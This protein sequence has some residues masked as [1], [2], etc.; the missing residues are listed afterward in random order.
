MTLKYL[1]EKEFKQFRRNS[2]L[3]KLVIMFPIMIM[4][5]IPWVATL[6]IKD[7]NITIVDR[8]NT[9]TSGKLIQKI[10]ASTYF[11][12]KEVVND[13]NLAMN[14][15][16]RGDADI[17]LEIPYG[18]ERHFVRSEQPQIYIAANAVNGTK[19]ALGSGY[20]NAIVSDF[21]AEVIAAQGD[22]VNAPNNEMSVLNLY[23]PTLNYRLF[24]I[25]AL[26]VM[27]VILLCGFLPTLNIVSEKE[28]GTIEQIN[29]TPV[30]KFQFI[31]AKLI[32]YWIIGLVVLTI[33]FALGWLVYG[34]LPAGSFIEIYVAAL[35]F[36]LA[37]SGLGLLVSNYSQTM[38][39]AMLVMF[40]FILIFNLMSGL[41]T[42]V[43]SMP[44]WAQWVAA[45]T[46]PKYFIEI[47]RAVFLRGSDFS[48][49]GR[50]YSVLALFAFGL[51]SVAV[52]SYRKRG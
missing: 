51:S 35:L 3:P 5:V 47:M 13:Y 27:V 10:G 1:I 42:P 38:Q 30:G 28:Q 50:Q 15:I 33:C 52:V 34:F 4:L 18:F 46:P 44:E 41:F 9:T 16:E 37:M 17:I 43:K 36:I 21:G 32:P 2:F 20:L 19:G 26:I 39:Q 48:D 14:S 12:L 31:L 7:V 40:F 11:I 29:V 49:L 24:M 8:D 6:D 22:A 23:N 45:F 25:P